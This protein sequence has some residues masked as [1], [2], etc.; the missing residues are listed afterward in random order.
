MS[1]GKQPVEAGAG[2]NHNICLLHDGGTAR[3]GAQFAGIG[4][5]PL[6]H[7]HGKVRNLVCFH[8]FFQLSLNACV[9]RTF[10]YDDGRL[11]CRCKK[12][13]CAFHCLWGWRHCRTHVNG[14]IE[15]FVGVGSLH[16][17]CKARFCYVQIYAAGTPGNGCAVGAYNGSWNIFGFV[18]AVGGFYKTFGN[19]ELVQSFVGPLVKV[20]RFTDTGTA[21]LNHRVAV[22][23]G[24]YSGGEAV[25][26]T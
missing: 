18:D 1:A 5:Y 7:R 4:K 13:R 22:H 21:Y 12:L 3:E 8:K 17:C 6:A 20:D 2:K 23:C 16:D 19:V 10:A 15:K 25:K 11:L 9:S 24:V 26:E 14:S